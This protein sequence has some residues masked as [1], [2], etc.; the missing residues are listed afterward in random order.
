MP[1]KL[2]H[3]GHQW[4]ARRCSADGCDNGRDCPCP[5][6]CEVPMRCGEPDFKHAAQRLAI[7]IV[8]VAV[9]AAVVIARGHV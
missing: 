3:D 1:A 7:A 6:A 4:P 5:E 2:Y 8:V 9:L